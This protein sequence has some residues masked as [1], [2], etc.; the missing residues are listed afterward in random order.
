MSIVPL[1]PRNEWLIAQFWS[2]LIFF[3]RETRNVFQSNPLLRGSPSAEQRFKDIFTKYRHCS[4]PLRLNV[5]LKQWKQP[6]SIPQFLLKPSSVSFY[7][8]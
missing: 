4:L 3:I 8:R 2:I 7:R 5:E 1:L 6:I